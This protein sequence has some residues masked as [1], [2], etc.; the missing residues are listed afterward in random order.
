MKVLVVLGHPNP[1]SF[2][3]AI[4]ANAVEKL[5]ENGH[6][7]VFHD[8]CAEQFD[9]MLP[10]R[11]LPEGVEISP[12]LEKHCQELT[13][14]DGIIIVHPNWWGQPPAILKGWVDRVFRPGV[15]Y[16][17]IEGEATAYGLLEAGC[18]LVFNTSETP[19][20]TENERF[21]DP[22]ETLWKNCTF[23]FC[24]VDNFYRKMFRVMVTSTRKL[25]EEW[26]A[27]VQQTVDFYF[28][29]G[30]EQPTQNPKG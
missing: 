25:R 9:P 15:A 11:E 6:E 26:L 20:E 4:A 30:A 14:A 8:L 18:A 23:A 5:R 2:N 29:K 13:E 16:Q 1:A 17:P 10:T 22:L 7:V 12:E 27:E 21:G 28:P 24:G 3:H 19:E